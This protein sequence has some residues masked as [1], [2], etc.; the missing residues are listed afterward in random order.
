MKY[1]D[2]KKG[3]PGKAE[4]FKKKEGYDMHSPNRHYSEVQGFEKGAG[5]DGYGL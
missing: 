3:E 4:D 5:M 1:V 2:F